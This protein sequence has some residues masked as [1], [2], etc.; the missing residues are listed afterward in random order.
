MQQPMSPKDCMAFALEVER[1]GALFYA[2]MATRFEGH[3]PLRE[4]LVSL[5]EDERL[6]E[7]MFARLFA[8]AST[9]GNSE[10]PDS[11][12]FKALALHRFF[13]GPEAPLANLDEIRSVP[14]MLRIALEFERDTLESFEAMRQVLGDHVNLDAIDRLIEAERLHVERLEAFV[15]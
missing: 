9:V 11:S 13:V 8:A 6:H 15:R 3:A 5:A 7:D 10:P 12:R 4:L 1:A 2:R 14:Q